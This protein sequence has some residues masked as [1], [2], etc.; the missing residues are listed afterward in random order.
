MNFIPAFHCQIRKS[1]EFVQK[2]GA[3]SHTGQG[4]RELLYG[5]NGSLSSSHSIVFFLNLHCYFLFHSLSTVIHPHLFLSMRCFTYNYFR[6]Q[7]HNTLSL[8]SKIM[9]PC[10]IHTTEYSGLAST[11]TEMSSL[12]FAMNIF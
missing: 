8:R 7:L 6:L 9:I 12:S 1:N 4:V 5:T 3:E 11:L 10:H 2:L